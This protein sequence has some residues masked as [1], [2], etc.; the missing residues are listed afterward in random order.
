MAWNSRQQ[1]LHQQAKRPSS[2]SKVTRVADDDDAIGVDDDWLSE[3][4]LLNRA[5]HGVNG[6]IVLARVLVVWTDLI[7]CA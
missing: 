6:G 3:F 7:N 1:R 2:I 5:S 4:K